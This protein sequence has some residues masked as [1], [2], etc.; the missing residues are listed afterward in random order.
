MQDAVVFRRGRTECQGW[1]RYLSD[2]S[3]RRDR[4]HIPAKGLRGQCFKIFDDYV[5][6][7]ELSR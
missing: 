5:G 3:R 4:D 7:I 2:R 1:A 6:L